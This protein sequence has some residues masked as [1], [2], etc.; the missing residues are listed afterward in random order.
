MGDILRPELDKANNESL[1]RL[2]EKFARIPKDTGQA[3]T[4]TLVEEAQGLAE[5]MRRVVPVGSGNLRE[6]IRV[7][8]G[9]NPLEVKI[10]AG[11]PLTSAKVRHGATAVYDYAIATEF[12][13]QKE[14]A[15]PFFFST[16]RKRKRQIR[17]HI[18]EAMGRS[19][20]EAEEFGQIIGSADAL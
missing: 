4:R 17:Q 16:Y 6:S 18:A 7:V 8:A 13:T 12:G 20:K 19:L 1:R 15:E 14:R 11:G 2:K 9:K 3:V 10:T 5:A